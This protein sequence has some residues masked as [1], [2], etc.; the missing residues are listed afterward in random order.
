MRRTDLCSLVWSKLRGQP[1]FDAL[2]A[3][4]FATDA[5]K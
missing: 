5:K 1:E 4:A 2:L 3:Q